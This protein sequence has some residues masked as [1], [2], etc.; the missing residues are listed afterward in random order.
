MEKVQCKV[1]KMIPTLHNPSYERRLQQLELIF[2]E[3]R[4]LRGQLIE[5]YKYPNGFNNVTLE[6][7]FDRHNNVQIRNKGYKLITRTFTTSQ[8]LYF[9]SV[10]IIRPWNQLFESTVSAATV[11]TFKNHLDKF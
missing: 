6:R 11:T 2:L 4:R 10:E 7:L 3:Q 1:T 5:T 8:A 9:F